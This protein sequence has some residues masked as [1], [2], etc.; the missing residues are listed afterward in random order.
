MEN[1]DLT[2]LINKNHDDKW[3]ALSRNYDR[4][5]SYDQNLNEL[6][7]RIDDAHI[8]A[9]YMKMPKFGR[10]YAFTQI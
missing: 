7:K 1:L 10:R 2:K 9:V 5:V 3:I 6:K 4:I 8:E